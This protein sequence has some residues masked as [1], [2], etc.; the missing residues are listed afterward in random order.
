MKPLIGHVIAKAGQLPV[1]NAQAYEY[2]MGANGVFIR[3]ER[4]NLAAMIPVAPAIEPI[5][6]L[7]RLETTFDIP[8]KV[9]EAILQRVLAESIAA[10]NIKP[11]PLEKLF[12]ILFYN[13]DWHL[14]I[15]AQIQ[16]RDEVK[17]VESGP[18]SSYAK[19]MIE[20]HSH[21]VMPAYFS[22]QDDLDEQGFRIY[23]VIGDFWA[24]V[25]EIRVRIGIHGHRWEIPAS[26]VFE[27]PE[28]ISGGMEVTNESS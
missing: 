9:P 12:H 19:A 8:K 11:E 23:C 17:P 22:P 13:D 27:M 18:D 14:V 5:R 28:S 1:Y 6:G 15:P 7:S 24:P 25:P 26:L 21:Q 10:A 4:E 16:K 20:V 3:S 2:V